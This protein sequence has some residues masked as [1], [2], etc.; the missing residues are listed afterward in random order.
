[1]AYLLRVCA[2]GVALG[3]LLPV[4]VNGMGVREGA[5]RCS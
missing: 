3:T 5:W 1:M 4:S 2:D